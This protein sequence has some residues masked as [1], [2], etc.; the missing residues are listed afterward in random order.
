M[1]HVHVHG[2]CAC[3]C[4][5][6]PLARA[7]VLVQHLTLLATT[8]LPAALRR[9]PLERVRRRALHVLAAR[10]QRRTRG[11]LRDPE[12]EQ[13]RDLVVVVRRDE[14]ELPA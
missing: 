13:A 9:D 14:G 5:W 10:E 3:A 7:A 2:A 8:L 4:A 6:L 1:V 11:M 12:A